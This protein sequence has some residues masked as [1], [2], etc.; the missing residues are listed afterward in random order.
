MS[1]IVELKKKG[2]PDYSSVASKGSYGKIC[3]GKKVGTDKVQKRFALNR[4]A[5]GKDYHF[6]LENIHEAIYTC[7]EDSTVFRKKLGRHGA[8][9]FFCVER[10]FT[11]YSLL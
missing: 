11:V 1:L 2:C 9:F 4:Y 5:A 10:G 3:F 6:R 8:T 7:G